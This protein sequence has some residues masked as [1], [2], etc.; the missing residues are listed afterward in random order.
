MCIL[1]KSTYVMEVLQNFSSIICGTWVFS[2]FRYWTT[3]QIP[4]VSLQQSLCLRS[5]SKVYY[6][7]LGAVTQR[8]Q[9]LS[10]GRDNSWWQRELFTAPF[11]SQ[12]SSPEVLCLR[13]T[14][15][16]HK[17]IHICQPTCGWAQHNTWYFICSRQWWK[18]TCL[19]RKQ[20]VNNP[21][22]HF[23]SFGWVQL[24]KKG[25]LALIRRG[26]GKA[27]LGLYLRFACLSLR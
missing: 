1:W 19:Y 24:V 13:R 27:Q 25:V 20:A 6:E 15:N 2:I 18:T 14:K 21:N 7:V 3:A 26:N 16:S 10:Q 4:R 11:L 9:S 5:Q 23:S 17:Q 22:S 8:C 12:P